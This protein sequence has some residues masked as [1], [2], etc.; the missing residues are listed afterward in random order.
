[1]PGDMYA[2]VEFLDEK[3][4]EVV[5]KSWIETSDGVSFTLLWYNFLLFVRQ[6]NEKLPY[7]PRK[8]SFFHYFLLYSMI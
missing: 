5:A 6:G 4:V 8:C 2:V 7:L 3:S 1:M